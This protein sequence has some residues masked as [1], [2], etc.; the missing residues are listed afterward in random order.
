MASLEKHFQINPENLISDS[1]MIFK[2]VNYR[3]TVLS[4]RLIRF[5]YSLDGKFYDGA[6]EIVHNRNF[7]IP[8]IKVEQDEKFLVITT[9]YFMMQYAKEINFWYSI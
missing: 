2:G 1:K 7:N 6:T 9:K 3:I 8:K 5:E 4:E